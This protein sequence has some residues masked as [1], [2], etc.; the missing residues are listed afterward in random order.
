MPWTSWFSSVA[1]WICSKSV[2]GNVPK[3]LSSFYCI[4][5]LRQQILQW[6]TFNVI[7]V[8]LC[9]V[10]WWRRQKWLTI[11]NNKNPYNRI[12]KSPT[13]GGKKKCEP[14]VSSSSC[15]ESC[16]SSRF[17][18]TR[19]KLSAFERQIIQHQSSKTSKVKLSRMKKNGRKLR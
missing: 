2:F 1:R 6:A 12:G 13:D 14:I 3:L 9:D 7:K 15:I 19:Y 16:A 4:K 5:H 17:L 8:G 11:R 10:L 18:V